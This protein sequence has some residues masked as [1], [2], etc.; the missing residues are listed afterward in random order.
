MESLVPF[1]MFLV[2]ALIGSILVWLVLRAR[3][4]RSY[5]D[6]QIDSE[7]KIA[8]LEERLSAKNNELQGLRETLEKG[9]TERE[10]LLG[11]LRTET[12]QRSAAEQKASRIAPLETEL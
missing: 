9:V 2:G 8:T 10:R 5:A 11:E 6:G 1:S 7:T 3:A 4:Q 12:D